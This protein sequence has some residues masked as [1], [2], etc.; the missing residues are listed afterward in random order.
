MTDVT[1]ATRMTGFAGLIH[2]FIAAFEAIPYWFLALLTR[3]SIAAVFWQSGETKVDGWHVTPS[4]IELFRTEYNLPLI[5]PVIAANLAAFAEHFFPLLLVLG[6]ATRFAALALLGMTLVIEIF[7]Y[8][9]AWPTHGTW[10]AC[11]ADDAR[12]RAGR[13]RSLDREMVRLN[14]PSWCM[15]PGGLAQIQFLE[16]V[17]ALI[18]D[19]DEG[20]EVDHLDAPSRRPP[21]GTDRRTN[22]CGPP[23][24]GRTRLTHSPPA[25]S[26]GRRN[27]PDGS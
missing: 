4:A 25:S 23:W 17:V 15:R 11:F 9:D 19:D 18:V 5:D 3:V 2:R 12:A 8:P 21:P 16:E 20:R 26:P 14:P 6:L 27:R 10:A 22:P 7:V 24:S 1:V 13:P